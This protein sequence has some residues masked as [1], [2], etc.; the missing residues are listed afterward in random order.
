MKLQK[1]TQFEKFLEGFQD[2][3]WAIECRFDP[4]YD[5]IDTERDE[6]GLKLFMDALNVGWIEMSYYE[7]T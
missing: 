3:L 1:R 2:T 7:K 6:N 4:E 5:A